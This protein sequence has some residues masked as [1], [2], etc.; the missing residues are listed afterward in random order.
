MRIR[1]A[2]ALFAAAGGV[3]LCSLALSGA[4]AV[5]L[6][7]DWLLE[8]ID[9]DPEALF[10]SFTGPRASLVPGR[11]RFAMLTLRSRDPNVEWEARLEDVTLRVALVPLAGR[12]LHV[13]AMRASAITFRLRE[14]LARDEATPARLAHYPP[15]AGFPNPPL[16]GSPAPR[17]PPGDPWRVVVDDLRVGRVRE[18]WIDSWH[19]EGE[20]R[21]A[22]GLRLRPGIEAEVRPSELTLEGGALAWGTDVVSRGIR[23]RVKAVLPRFLTKAYPGNEVWRIVSGSAS[24]EG[25]LD[26]VPFLSPQGD[27][28]RL[29]AGGSVG[30][31]VDVSG[32]KGKGHLAA[33][34]RDARPL[35]ALLP[36][37]PPRWIAGLVGL[38]DLEFT[39]RLEGRPGMLALS[40]AHAAS[41][42]LSI[43]ADLREGNGRRWGAVLFRK[44]ALSTGLELGE[45][46]SLHLL[47][48][49]TWFDEEGRSGGLRT[50]QPRGVAVRASR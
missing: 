12:R 4:T 13:S 11:I 38:R 14:R 48:A 49:V 25:S 35:V 32:A 33:R 23:G 41:G 20:G 1:P 7:S 17:I 19:W 18:I 30:L 8:E 15:I 6:R 43:D 27:G 28:P 2:R 39:A 34:I 29:A 31:S 3:A 26:S 24:L 45:K 46:T 10:V 36:S 44:G 47:G 42:T 37:G 21:L 16:R 22:G 9:A 5:V 50:D 40:P